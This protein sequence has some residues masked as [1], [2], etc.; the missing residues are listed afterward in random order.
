[1]CVCVT[2]WLPSCSEA[3][4]LLGGP[5]GSLPESKHARN[6][7]WRNTVVS[8][9]RPTPPRAI[10][11]FNTHMGPSASLSCS[12]PLTH[13]GQVCQKSLSWIPWKRP[14]GFRKTH[15]PLPVFLCL[16][17]LVSDPV[18]SNHGSLWIRLPECPRKEGH[19]SFLSYSFILVF[20]VFVV[21]PVI[22]WG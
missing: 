1:M 6:G 19:L 16:S 10:T 18:Q 21:L 4:T 9:A 8:L 13:S 17:S 12:Y 3:M 7:A 11:V 5:L 20:C 2:K 14:A 22:N 15:S